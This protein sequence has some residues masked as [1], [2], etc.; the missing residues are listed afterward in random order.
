ML[1]ADDV[2]KLETSLETITTFKGKDLVTRPEWGEIDFKEAEANIDLALSI[3]T[4]LSELP[5]EYLTVKVAQEIQN[6]IP[7]VSKCLRQI[8]T[9]SI[10]DAGDVAST[11]GDYF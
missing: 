7:D 9:F 2:A 4:D 10:R 8:D 3:A 6:V 5:L 1:N 11:Q